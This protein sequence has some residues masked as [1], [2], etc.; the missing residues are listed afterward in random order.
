MKELQSQ[1]RLQ[2]LDSAVPCRTYR[3]HNVRVAIAYKQ[4]RALRQSVSAL[5][6][7]DIIRGQGCSR[8]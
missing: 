6:N 7:V 4:D 5:R 3:S 2:Q 8:N 1:W